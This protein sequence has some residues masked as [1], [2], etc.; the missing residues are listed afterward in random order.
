MD[1]TMSRIVLFSLLLASLVG[2]GGGERQPDA[3]PVVKAVVEKKPEPAPVKA[4]PGGWG[5]ITGRITWGGDAIPPRP[6]L[7]L[8]MHADEKFCEKDGK[9]MD[10]EWIVDPKNKGLK[11]AFIW[12]E[13][14]A[15]GEK[16]PIHPD[17]EK[18]EATPLEIDQPVCMF[19][20]H[21][22]A[23]RQGRVLRVKNSSGIVH[24]FKYDGVVAG[25]PLIPPG[26]VAE[27]A[28]LQADRLPYAL[29]CS[30]H[31]W[32]RGWARVFDHPY[33]AVTDTDGGF[34]F[35]KAPAGEFRLKI[36]HGSGGWLGGKDG[37]DGRPITIKAADNDLGAIPYPPP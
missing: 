33:F 36:W 32:M 20:P 35:A 1:P 25:N 19:T 16:L 29:S 15:K 2:C 18:V 7:D 28:N 27:I 8:K 24:N 31:P 23:L 30:I 26:G 3:P 13:P 12:L 4:A 6:Q 22:F 17:L 14:K 10:E 37:R 5:T 9:I 21:G 34:K 11:N